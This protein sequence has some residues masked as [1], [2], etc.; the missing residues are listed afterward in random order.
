MFKMAKKRIRD[1]PSFVSRRKEIEGAKNLKKLVDSHFLDGLKHLGVDM[2]KISSTL[3]EV[4]EHEEMLE[5]IS[6]MPDRFNQQF[7]KY[8]WI[9]HNLM[10]FDVMKKAVE[11]AEEGKFDIAEKTLIDYYDKNLD[12]QILFLNRVEEF[13]PRMSLIQKAKEDYLEERYHACIPVILMMIDG[14]VADVKRTKDQKGFHA[15][16]TDLEAWDSITA[17][18]NGLAELQKVLNQTRKKTRI[19]K[20]DIPYRNGILHGRD[21]GYDNK[22]VGIKTWATLFAVRDGLTD[23]KKEP[24]EEPKPTIKDSLKNYRDTEIL[25]KKMDE[26]KPRDLKAKIDFSESE[27][28]YDYGEGTPERLFVEFLEFWIKGN[29]YEMVKRMCFIFSEGQNPGRFAGELRNDVLPSRKLLKYHLLDI[30]DESVYVTVIEVK[31]EIQD[32][33]G[34]SSIKYVFRMVY[35]DNV[36]N[37][38]VRDD[39]EG[40]WKVMT[41]YPL[42]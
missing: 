23:M 18:I 20:I 17:H 26:W 31:L 15:K 3:S 30:K 14:V 9:A 12:V 41:L 19:E 25:K 5:M 11:L 27:N 2:E 24:K 10:N 22:V 34:N 16:D 8:G 1:N 38:L 32:D 29:Y 35:E 21:L 39:V 33:T 37:Y 13:A 7:T 6:N 28:S 40:S 42:N 4:P 36:G